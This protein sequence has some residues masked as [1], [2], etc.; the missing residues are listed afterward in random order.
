MREEE[1]WASGCNSEEEVNQFWKL[2]PKP[3]N[4]A[5]GERIYWAERGLITSWSPVLWLG[6]KSFTC[7]VSGKEWSGYHAQL[8]RT[9]ILEGSRVKCGSGLQTWEY[10]SAG[11]Q[12]C[13]DALKSALLTRE[14]W[15]K[16]YLCDLSADEICHFALA[17]E[18]PNSPGRWDNCI[19]N[20]S[21]LAT[22]EYR[23]MYT[24]NDRILVRLAEALDTK[25]TKRWKAI[26]RAKDSLDGLRHLIAPR[27]PDDC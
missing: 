19:E 27:L 21:S 9:Q 16:I 23:W 12:R 2:H 26:I 14:T 17:E 1:F 4:L 6:E 25:D 15:W 5:A 7:Q 20:F 11:I 24:A 13:L 8:G 3:R 18:N 10:V 22:S